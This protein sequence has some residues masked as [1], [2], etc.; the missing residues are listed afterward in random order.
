MEKDFNTYWEEKAQKRRKSLAAKAKRYAEQHTQ[1]EDIRR[2]VFLPIDYTPGFEL[3][4]YKVLHY[5]KKNP[6]V[7]W[8]SGWSFAFSE[9]NLR[10]AME[11]E[12]ADM[13]SFKM[14]INRHSLVGKEAPQPEVT[15][16]YKNCSPNKVYDIRDEYHQWLKRMYEI[17]T[18]VQTCKLTY[19]QVTMI[20]RRYATEGIRFAYYEV[21]PCE[22]LVRSAMLMEETSFNRLNIATLLMEM[23]AEFELRQEEL[24]YHAKQLKIRTMEAITTVNIEYKFW[25]DWKLQQKMIEYAE[26]D[27][28]LDK[29]LAAVLQPWMR[30]VKIFM[31]AIIDRDCSGQDSYRFYNTNRLLKDLISHFQSMGLQ[32][33][34]SYIPSCNENWI[35]MEC[36]GYR[37]ILKYNNYKMYFYPYADEEDLQN[38]LH[39]NSKRSIEL[40]RFTLSA[41]AEYLKQVPTISPRIAAMKTKVK[42]RYNIILKQYGHSNQ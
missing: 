14:E 19:G 34:K 8:Q 42:E 29:V 11:T 1:L 37:T 20:I 7:D 31:N 33:V 4:D 23:A 40:K 9:D 17:C 24:N 30:G 2:E 21:I 15:G 26:K 18:D 39:C 27:Y 28:P 16:Y 22:Q 38:Q 36:Q 32:D 12:G 25:D 5:T 3:D 10:Q 41:I 35:I 6:I 13:N